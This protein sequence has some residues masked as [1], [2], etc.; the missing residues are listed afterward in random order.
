MSSYTVELADLRA[1][2]QAVVVHASADKNNTRLRRVRLTPFGVNLEVTATDRYTA[3]LAI[4]SVW[5]SDGDAEVVELEP[6]E[7]QQVL[8]VFPAPGK[9]ETAA[10]R[11]DVT[12]A[13]VT[14]IETGALIDGKALILPRRT[15]EEQYPNLRGL[16]MGRLQGDTGPS[17]EVWFESSHLG[18]FAA[19]QRVYGY[20]LILDRVPAPATFWL[21][22]C[23]ESFLGMVTPVPADEDARV[24]AK[25]HRDAWDER[26]GPIATPDAWDLRTALGGA[27]VFTSRG[28]ERADLDEDHDA[29][30]SAQP[31]VD[32]PDGLLADAARLVITTQ[33]ASTPML[34]RK[35]RVGFARAGRLMDLLEVH[36]VVGPADG[37]K[38][39][40]VLVAPDGLDAAL[41]ALRGAS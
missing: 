20:P 30:R 28:L 23:G 21:V 29:P 25:Q 6:K 35:L 22:R 11:V 40:A 18:K 32:A 19:A 4:A 17:A 33:F 8:T 9:G 24:E 41:S 36:A 26:L 14:F 2:L 1:A 10:L 15:P 34:Q 7:V 12:D 27:Y 3:G 5:S 38:A 37:A 31:V 13:E 39:R 16:F